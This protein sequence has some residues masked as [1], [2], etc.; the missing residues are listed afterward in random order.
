MK[1]TRST[2]RSGI[3]AIG[4]TLLSIAHAPGVAAQNTIFYG[5]SYNRIVPSPGGNPSASACVTRL[6]SDLDGSPPYGYLT[7]VPPSALTFG[8]IT[9]LNAVFSFPV[10]S[11]HGG[12]P[13][14][15]IP[16]D[17]DG[18][19]SANGS[20]FVYMGTP[21]NFTDPGHVAFAGTGNVIGDVVTHWD[22]TQLGGPYY[23]TYA[24]ALAL[25][26]TGRVLDV[27]LVV[28]GG[29]GGDQQALADTFT[30]NSYTYS[31]QCPPPPQ[32]VPSLSEWNLILLAGLL[33]WLAL[34]RRARGDAHRSSRCRSRAEPP[35][36]DATPGPGG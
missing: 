36:A 35:G 24:Q 19:D 2:V 32:P 30:V 3:A 10:G 21:P 16:V 22:L 1:S 4:L 6:Q 12:S 28:D 34:R 11:Y 13:R 18:D 8:Q 20:I 17:T 29:W 15:E 23:G 14:F 7:F 5:S 9:N 31:T 33:G 27:E 26:S 25:L